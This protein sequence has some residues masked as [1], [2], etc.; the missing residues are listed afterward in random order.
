MNA[1]ARNTID[2]VD[3]TF[4]YIFGIS[5]LMLLGITLCMVWFAYRYHHSRHP[6]PMSD[7]KG[8]PLI[9]IVWTIIPSLLVLSMFWYGWTSF[10]N[11]R[12]IPEDAFALKATARMWSWSFEYENGLTSDR[13]RVPTGQAIEVS[14]E[15][16][17]VLHSF[18]LPA[19]RVKRDAVPGMTTRVWF[20]PEQDGEYNLFCAEYC[21]TGH[22]AM[23]SVVEAMPQEAFDRW[24]NQKQMAQQA[25]ELMK[26]Q[27]CLGCHS[28]DGAVSVGPTFQNFAGRERTLVLPDASKR[29]QLAD[30][31]YTRRSILEPR[32]ELV[33]H[34]PAI[35]PSFQG[36]MSDEELEMI[37][38]WLLAQRQEDQKPDGAKIFADK[39][40]GGC[41]SFD[42]S[43]GLGPSLLGVF[44]HEARVQSEGALRTFIADE[45]YLRES[46]LNPKAA[47]VEGYA[48]LM[49]EFSDLSTAELDA[50]VE[51]LKGLKGEHRH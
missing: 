18:Y 51:Y 34:L 25:L 31:A 17:D 3:A 27:G 16:L 39:G 12:D 48:P 6:E 20:R 49:P 43:K 1:D 30:R 21:G 24:Y 42:G 50:L 29:T 22:S 4:F 41:H 26:K 8:H 9:E 33:E 10:T 14:I 47:V 2:K 46:I 35:M 38:D 5:A 7:S 11:L 36:R 13:L 28:L 23:I 15:S 44:G 45:A 37:V 19:F 32:A 40:C